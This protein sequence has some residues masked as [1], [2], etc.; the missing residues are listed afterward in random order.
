MY[1]IFEM[2]IQ[3]VQLDKLA[4][5]LFAVISIGQVLAKNKDYCSLCDN[6]VACNNNGVSAIPK[7]KKY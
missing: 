6:H 4:I 3:C 1:L 2:A 7:R 5:L